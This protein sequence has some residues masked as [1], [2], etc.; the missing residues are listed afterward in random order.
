MLRNK[1][2]DVLANLSDLDR[3]TIMK[4]K[5]LEQMKQD[6]ADNHRFDEAKELKD[7]I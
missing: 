7:N 5:T 6:A 2:G 3:E 4:L 1:E